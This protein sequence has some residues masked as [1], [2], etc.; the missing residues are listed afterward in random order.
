[1]H[2]RLSDWPWRGS[3]SSAG[4]SPAS[5]SPRERRPP[6]ACRQTRLGKWSP[7]SIDECDDDHFFRIYSV[8]ESIVPGEQL[9]VLTFTKLW[10]PA[11]AIGEVRKRLSSFEKIGDELG[12]GRGRFVSQATTDFFQQRGSAWSPPYST[13]HFLIRALTSS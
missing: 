3:S 2:C 1:M 7:I 12:R 9:A 4:F 8:D 5:A 6:A 13:S 11:A 10:N